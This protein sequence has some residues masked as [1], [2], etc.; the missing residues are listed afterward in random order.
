[1]DNRGIGQ[2]SADATS[3]SIRQ[4]ADDAAGLIHALGLGP[5]HVAGHSMGGLIAQE[6][7]LAF[8]HHIRSLT[9]IATRAEND[10]RGKAIIESWGDLARLVDSVTLTRIILPW[11]YTRAFYSRPRAIEQ[12]LELVLA[13]PFPPSA[14][15][16]FAQTRAIAAC[17]T[18]ARLGK[19][20]CPTIVIAG[21]EDILM[22][23]EFSE[24]LARAITGAELVVLEGT[25]HG[26][27]IESPDV[28][29]NAMLEFLSRHHV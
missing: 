4:M 29:A 1:L 15:I 18:V 17:S 26:L 14:E 11:M 21:R 22:P 13:N 28:V 5:V 16:L 6:L 20:T 8:P 19:L 12:V 7:A 25:G 2:S 3:I 24:R 27:V 10:E 23:V 9:L